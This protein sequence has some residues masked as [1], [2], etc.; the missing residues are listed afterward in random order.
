MVENTSVVVKLPS[1]V[2]FQH[3]RTQHDRNFR[4]LI[5]WSEASF[6]TLPWRINRTFYSTLIS[7]LMLQQTTVAGV[8][9]KYAHFI[10]VYP[11]WTELQK[12]SLSDLLEIWKGLGYY[13]RPKSLYTLLQQ[14]S[15]EEQLIQNVLTYKKQPGIGPYTHGAL[16]SIGLNRPAEALDANIRRVLGRYVGHEQTFEDVY[17]DLLHSHSPRALNEALMD[18]GREYCQARRASCSFCPLRTSCASS[19]NIDAQLIIE[20]SLKTP[21][22]KNTL[23]LVR[24]CCQNPKGSYMGYLKPPKKWLSGYIELPTW[25]NPS[26]TPSHQYPDIPVSLRTY[27]KEHTPSVLKTKIT[28]Y[29]LCSSVYILPFSFVYSGIGVE[30]FGASTENHFYS[31]DQALWAKSSLKAIQIA[32]IASEPQFEIRKEILVE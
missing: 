11:S 32:A 4:D 17:R 1:K 31:L 7:E 24:I 10:S 16:L 28:S 18:L 26:S 19:E 30:I 22:A 6:H 9:Q 15:S 13:Q 8:C 2:I 27:L 14:T 12:A 20:R 21:P 25:K 5:S 3:D 23:D 29:T